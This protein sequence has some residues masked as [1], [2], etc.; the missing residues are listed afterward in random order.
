M[1]K[2][3]LILLSIVA[4][5][6]LHAQEG[7]STSYFEKVRMPKTYKYYD[8]D[9]DSLYQNV[10]TLQQFVFNVAV[11]YQMYAKK[12]KEDRYLK[13]GIILN[14]KPVPLDSLKNIPWNKVRNLEF[15]TREVKALF[16]SITHSGVFFIETK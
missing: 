11:S 13:P 5:T 7:D 8:S 15:K 9:K 14:N 10:Q 6:I 2:T 12:I 1:K 16:P 4:T 3:I